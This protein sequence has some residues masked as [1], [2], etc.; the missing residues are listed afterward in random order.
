MTSYNVFHYICITP[1][2]ESRC[3]L[4]GNA[5]LSEYCESQCM[6]TFTGARHAVLGL[7][8]GLYMAMAAMLAYAIIDL[9]DDLT[10]QSHA[11]RGSV[12]KIVLFV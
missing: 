10:W 5:T 1:Q 3:C 4:S 12:L 2:S 8:L 9:T 11:V 6:C 7:L